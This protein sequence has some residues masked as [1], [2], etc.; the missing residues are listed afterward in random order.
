[1]KETASRCLGDIQSIYDTCGCMGLCARCR[2][3][4]EMVG[5]GRH[6]VCATY[7]ATPDPVEEEWPEEGYIYGGT[8]GP[9]WTAST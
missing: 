3:S 9:Q 4:G 2:A 1:M 5:C 8:E 6:Y 7:H